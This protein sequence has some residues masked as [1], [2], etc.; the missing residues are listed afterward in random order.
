MS[1][2]KQSDETTT[3]V[4]EEL[5]S[6]P[7]EESL[8][9]LD[10]DSNDFERVT[11]MDLPKIATYGT[12][13]LLGRIAF[14]GMA[15]IFLARELGAEGTRRMTVIKRVLPHVAED[16]T[17]VEM[18]RDEARLAMQLNHP[19]ICHVY[20]FGEAEGTYYL[21]MEWVNGKPLS[22]IIKRAREHGGLPIP[23]ALRIIAQVAEALDYAHRANGANGEPLG[24]VHRDVSPQN[25][26]VSYDGVVKLLDFG[27]AKATSHSTRTEAGVIKGKFAYMSPQQCVGELIDSRAD[28]FALGI[29][30]FEALA[31]RNPFRRKTEFETMTKIVGDPTPDLIERRED[32]TEALASVVEK[33]L[34]KQPERR[35]QT[36]G[37]LQLALEQ[38]LATGGVL[39]NAARVGDYVKAIFPEDVR[40][41]P[42]LDTRIGKA[43]SVPPSQESGPIDEAR[44][45]SPPGST[46]LDAVAMPSHISIAPP[47]Q[48]GTSPIVWVLS[49][50][51]LLTGLA[52]A[53]GV[54]AWT[55]FAPDGATDPVA[56]AEPP[57]TTPA[58]PTPPPS[59]EPPVTEPPAVASGSVFLESDPPG[60]SIRFDDRDV[61]GETP[62]EIGMVEP[63]V[64]QVVLT[65][66][67]HETWEGNVVVVA[68][69][70]ATLTG[71]LTRERR[72][73]RVA[74]GPPGQLSLNTR[75][76]SKVYLGR[77]LIGTTPIGRAE[78]PSGNVRL[79]LVDRDGAEHRRSVRVPAGGHVSE[80]FDLRE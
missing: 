11:L 47:P 55:F 5:A 44:R 63:G 65:L 69:R 31:G 32:V 73:P 2:A 76:W 61:A 48:S 78:V 59:V 67:G 71:D 40:D 8:E 12:Y 6:I 56:V 57:P 15:E 64:H 37:D 66:D 30:L 3:L 38:Q 46:E 33:A 24:I 13:E 1:Q 70:R 22:K 79:R 28:I 58:V 52:V 21:A 77:R 68:G 41:G 60:A 25:V 45:P 72:A 27:I 20:T 16:Q 39:V 4:D 51:L 10:L 23:I 54:V 34:M 7:I 74:G 26:M 43:P 75:P 49:I 35:Y 36:A 62:V 53:G 19:H 42:S 50:L 17:F 9:D 80:S 18:F 29:C 14:G